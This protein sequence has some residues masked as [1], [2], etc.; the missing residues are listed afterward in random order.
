MRQ[1]LKVRE[2]A[3]GKDSPEVARSLINLGL[4]LT[5]MGEPGEAI[6]SARA[7]TG[8]IDERRATR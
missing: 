7:S 8:D 4:V 1:A 6:K 2:K 5:E 3:F